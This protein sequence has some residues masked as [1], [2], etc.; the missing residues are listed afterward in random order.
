MCT[1]LFL[2]LLFARIWKILKE[3]IGGEGDSYRTM[4]SLD[5]IFLWSFAF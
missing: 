3:G 2:I 4:T 1:Y 5:D